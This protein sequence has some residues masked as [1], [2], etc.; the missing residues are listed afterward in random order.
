MTELKKCPL[1]NGQTMLCQNTGVV[2]ICPEFSI[3]C[4]ECGVEFK[5]HSHPST[6]MVM[7]PAEAAKRIIE[8]FNRREVTP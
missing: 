2:S 3:L 7:E 4:L 5:I 6:N 1:C 8:R